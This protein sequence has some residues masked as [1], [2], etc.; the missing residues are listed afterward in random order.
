[1]RN[2]WKIINTDAHRIFS[3]VVVLVVLMG[4][5]VVPCLYS[6]FNVFS[7]WDPYGQSATSRIRV[8]IAN[9]DRGAD[10]LGI[11]LKV[12]AQVVEGLQANDQI[13]WVFC[14]TEDDALKRVYSGDCYAALIV[15]ESFS[16][17]IVSFIT[18]KFEHP[19]LQYYENG[20]KNAIAPKITGKAKTAVQEQVNTTFLQTLANTAS[21]IVS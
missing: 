3:S 21:E 5:C 19:T 18:M 10:L 20:K 12:G 1:M 7:N 4:L 17:D 8:A 2:I 15:P 11:E 6:W 9:K 14:D 16:R 13:G